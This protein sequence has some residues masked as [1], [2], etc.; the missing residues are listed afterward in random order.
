MQMK[1]SRLEKWVHR[2]PSWEVHGTE[3][4]EAVSPGEEN[5]C[6]NIYRCVQISDERIKKG[7]Q[8]LFNGIP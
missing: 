7:S 3:G 8:T 1:L 6:R 4:D 2:A 5:V